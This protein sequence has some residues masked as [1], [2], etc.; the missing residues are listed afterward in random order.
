MKTAKR[1]L[2]RLCAL[3]LSSLVS[4]HAAA[5]VQMTPIQASDDQ[6][7]YSKVLQLMGYQFEFADEPGE[8]MQSRTEWCDHWR[9]AKPT[10]FQLGTMAE[11]AMRQGMMEIDPALAT[12]LQRVEFALQMK[13]I[14]VFRDFQRYLDSAEEALCKDIDTDYFSHFTITYAHCRMTMRTRNQTM[15][16]HMPP[17]SSSAYMLA[18]DHEK[19]EGA[20]A[21]L[22]RDLQRTTPVTGQGWSSGVSMTPLG[23]S[24]E[25]LGYTTHKYK[26]EY[27]AGMGGL[28]TQPGM[29]WIARKISVKNEGKASIAPAVEGDSIPKRFY[30]NLATQ[31][32][33]ASGASGF[34]SGLIM[35]MVGLMQH[36]LPLSI[37][38]KVT[39]KIMGKSV[40]S[41]DSLSV[42]TDVSLKPM[43]S[44]YC[45]Q[46]IVPPD[47][48]IT[49]VGE[50][51]EKALAQQ[52]G[53]AG[54]A[55]G[56]PS[57][58]E[59]EAA[60]QQ[61]EEAMA[62]MTPEQKQM[63]ESMGL[64]DM[65]GM[66]GAAAVG[67]SAGAA[68]PPPASAPTPSPSKKAG[69]QDSLSAALQGKNLTE[70][71]KNYLQVLGYDTGEGGGEMNLE[72]T[73]AISQF[74]AENGMEATGEVTPQLIGVLAAKV[75]S[76]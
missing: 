64:G 75:D 20:M 17:G 36:G 38:S 63:M 42:I 4:L 76:L 54:S 9:V 58:A 18:V 56:M 50:E 25:Y 22:V 61:M 67:G 10:L 33:P 29:D 73:I 24:E 51:I 72:T 14:D 2:R 5:A 45:E 6:H 35:N 71:A 66:G 11:G 74:Q 70:T 65:M 44:G 69:S 68:Q 21:D 37:E 8:M 39:S 47:F 59:M 19:Q 55:P 34:F 28:G 15:E 16:I 52:G 40:I 60:M 62:Q 43:P 30:W 12:L 31:V 27:T 49:N 46:D 26:Y 57:N 13:G 48:E 23:I 32:Q 41:G 53:S 3:A 1:Y 7:T